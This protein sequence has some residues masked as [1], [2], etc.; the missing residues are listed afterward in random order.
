MTRRRRRRRRGGPRRARAAP[1][2][3][4]HGDAGRERGRRCSR[5]LIGT[6]LLPALQDRRTGRRA[7]IPEPHVVVPDRARGVLVATSI[8][9]QLACARHAARRVRGRARFLLASRSSSRPA[10]SLRRCT[11][12]RDQLQRF[13]ISSDAY[14]SIYYTLLGAD[15]AHVFVG[16]LLQ[17]L[18]A[19]EARARP[20]DLPR[21]RRAGDRLLL[22][23]RQR[24]HDRRRPRRCSRRRYERAPTL[25]APVVRAPA[26]RRGAWAVAAPRRLSAS[27]RRTA[28]PAARAG[29][30]SNGLWQAALMVLAG[31]ARARGRGRRARGLRARRGARRA[32]TPSEPP[33]GPPPLLRARPRSRRTSIFLM[34][35]AAR[36]HRR[37]DREHRRAAQSLRRGRSLASRSRALPR[38][39][40]APAAAAAGDR[41]TQGEHLYGQLLRRLPR[42]RTA[43]ASAAGTADRRRRRGAPRT[44]QHGARARAARRRRAG[45][46][47]LPAHRLHAARRTSATQPRRS[48]VLLDDGQIRALIAY[49]ASLGP[50]RRSR[51]RTRSAAD[52]GRGPAAVHRPLRRL[53]PGRRR[54]RLRDR[55]AWRR[56][57]SDATAAQI[58]EAVRIG[59]YL[60]PRFSE[61]QISDARARLDHRLRP[62]REAPGRPRRLGARPHRP[63]AGGARHLVRRGRRRSSAICMVIGKRLRT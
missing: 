60:M 48:R 46:G 29:A 6:L 20:H 31:S 61:A 2:L 34:I 49:V 59:P 52:L 26:R 56:R 36:R 33:R 57:S 30:S 21:E 43:R 17:R 32:T 8:P 54:G 19:R 38:A 3:V 58:A 9:M 28:T 40:A 35:I 42:R 25:R 50:A 55:R 22:A 10:T 51:R 14:S 53:P 18:A 63:G 47:L 11:T 44:Q 13:R 1:A 24:P 16:I 23:L 12:T 39:C 15:H 37:L 41:R 62:V 45:R 7:A 4:G 27:R 5:A